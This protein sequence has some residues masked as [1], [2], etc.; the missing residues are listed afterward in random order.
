[1]ILSLCT[2]VVL[3]GCTAPLA[4]V[5][6]FTPKRIGYDVKTTAPIAMLEHH[7]GAA[8]SAWRK[9]DRDPSYAEAREDHNFAVARIFGTLRETKM[10]PWQQ[11]IKT[12]PHTLTWMDDAPN[13]SDGLVP[14]WSSHLPD[15]QSDKIVPS[16]QNAQQHPDAIKEVHRILQLHSKTTKSQTT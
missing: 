13:S 8:E 4:K 15:A 12:G 7:V 5:T 11:P 3:A 9:L 14:Y 6:E 10:A 2:A 16:H 1:M